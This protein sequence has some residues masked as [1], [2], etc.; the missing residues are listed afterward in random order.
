M[1]HSPKD[2][3]IQ[4]LVAIAMVHYAI[5]GM[6][7]EVSR[8]FDWPLTNPEAKLKWLQQARIAIEA[9]ES[10]RA[11]TALASQGDEEL[12]VSMCEAYRTDNCTIE[13]GM[14]AVLE[15]IRPYLRADK[16]EDV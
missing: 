3:K 5:D 8:K 10:A 13:R 6:P 4:E 14:K 15:A 16:S 12:L 2:P 1:T 9:Y 11:T 7:P